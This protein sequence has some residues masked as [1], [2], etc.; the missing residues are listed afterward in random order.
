M[1]KHFILIGLVA[2]MSLSTQVHAQQVAHEFGTCLTDSLTGKER[3]A[4]A[5]W[6][7]FA[8]AAHPEINTYA[9]VTKDEKQK[10]DKEIGDLI[11]R[12]L[13]NDCPKQAKAAMDEGGSKAFEAAFRIVGQVAM[14]ELMA[15]PDV[16]AS[17]S[18]FEKYMDSEKINKALNALKKQ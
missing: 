8:M 12:L 2:S 17:I 3:K 11:T 1:K 7:F 15:N 14:Q 4:L 9:Q 6:I 5:K 18:G 10:T 13:V 16:T